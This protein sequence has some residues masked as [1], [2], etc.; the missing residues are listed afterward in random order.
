MAERAIDESLFAWPNDNPVLLASR[1][2][3]CGTVSFPQQPGCPRCCAANSDT[4]ELPRRG[5]L[6]SW[7]T[8][9]FPPHRPP[10]LGGGEGSDY[11]PFR[12]GYVQLDDVVCVEARI[13][14]GCT[15]PLII[16]MP[17]GLVI[18]ELGI[19]QDGTRVMSYAFEPVVEPPP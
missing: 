16:G 18:E 13:A 7:T 3:N 2:E 11:Q 9:E 15:Q 5:T 8:Q 17:M 1:C 19:D 12:L 6:W 10:F 4:V 14:K